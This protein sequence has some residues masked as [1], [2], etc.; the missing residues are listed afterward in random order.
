MQSER[1]DDFMRR[2]SFEF[3]R[4]LEEREGGLLPTRQYV[5]SWVLWYF[6]D[7]LGHDT[8]TSE[9]IARVEDWFATHPLVLR[10][11]SLEELFDAVDTNRAQ[12]ISVFRSGDSD[13]V[14]FD[15]A[16]DLFVEFVRELFSN[17]GDIV[18]AMETDDSFTMTADWAYAVAAGC[19][20]DTYE[21]E[22]E[23]LFG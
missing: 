23:S 9:D 15:K 3:L 5:T 22:I 14:G 6:C 2:K 10:K 8:P 7:C 12:V 18:A 11:V 16:L 19:I 21:L 4:V 13:Y 1:W 17:F 20:Y